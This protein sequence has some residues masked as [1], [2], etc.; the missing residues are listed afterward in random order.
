LGIVTQESLQEKRVL[1]VSEAEKLSRATYK[2]KIVYVTFNTEMSQRRCIRDCSTGVLEEIFNFQ[3]FSSE[4]D[5]T[6]HG[7]VLKIDQ[8][9]EP[10]EVLYENLHI[11]KF[12][13]YFGILKAYSLTG[14]ILWISYAILQVRKRK[15]KRKRGNTCFEGSERLAASIFFLVLC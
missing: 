14:C 2:P 13:F 8:P 11:G 9:V 6:F 10:S 7:R 15:T 4:R 12:A 3:C 5:S 1:L